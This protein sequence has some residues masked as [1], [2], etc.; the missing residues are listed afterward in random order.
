M[1]ALYAA[2]KKKLENSVIK[3]ISEFTF[4]NYLQVF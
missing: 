3:E 4:F 2:E 1:K